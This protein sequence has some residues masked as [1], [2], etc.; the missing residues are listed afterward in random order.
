MCPRLPGHGWQ[1][2]NSSPGGSDTTLVYWGWQHGLALWEPV[3]SCRSLHP[4]PGQLS[5]RSV[6]LSQVVSI[7]KV[8]G[9]T[10]RTAPEE[11]VPEAAYSEKE[12]AGSTSVSLY[13]RNP[14]SPHRAS[15]AKTNL[16]ILPCALLG[17]SSGFVHLWQTPILLSSCPTHPSHSSFQ[18]FSWSIPSFHPFLSTPAVS[19]WVLCFIVSYPGSCNKLWTASLVPGTP[20]PRPPPTKRLNPNHTSQCIPYGAPRFISLNS[21]WCGGKSKVHR[22]K[23][24]ASS[25]CSIADFSS[26]TWVEL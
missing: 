8:R 6:L 3:T 2:W 21:C 18:R 17:S 23:R 22:V 20:L 4:T 15:V 19:T 12:A 5:F 26:L 16:Q 7:G 25:A 1:T 9:R 11:S 14:G 24:F 13:F 10:T